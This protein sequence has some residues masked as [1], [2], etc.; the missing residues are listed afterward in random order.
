MNSEGVGALDLGPNFALDFS[1]FQCAE[2]LRSV[3]PEIAG[4]IEQAG[5]CVRGCDRAPAVGFPLA[6]EGQVQAKVRVR[7][8]FRILGDF[9]QPRTRNDDAGGGD[10]MFVERV[11]A[12]GVFGVSDGEIVGVND[13]EFRI[14]G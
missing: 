14:C 7:M 8:S 10:S 4:W 3:G 6:G 1:G 9:A 5:D 11:E 2:G 13:E 12:G